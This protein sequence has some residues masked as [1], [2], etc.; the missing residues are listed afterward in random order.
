M[1]AAAAD[2]RHLA[3]C[4]VPASQHCV[5]HTLIYILAEQS[6][7]GG[8][9]GSNKRVLHA[10]RAVVERGHGSSAPSHGS[11]L[12]GC[13]AFVPLP[14]WQLMLP[15]I[16]S[17]ARAGCRGALRCCA[18]LGCGLRS[19]RGLQPQ[20]NVALSCSGLSFSPCGRQGEQGSPCQCDREVRKP[21]QMAASN[22]HS[23]QHTAGVR[24]APHSAGRA[25]GL[26]QPHQQRAT[27]APP[28]RCP[29]PHLEAVVFD[30]VEAP[31]ARLARQLAQLCRR[32]A[33][34]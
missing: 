32:G 16:R 30:A 1:S 21:L 23:S 4:C 5:R 12:G 26:S 15:S 18:A 14:P 34:G 11:S 22:A 20:P 31:E 19:W 3:M 10:S 17:S 8:K 13:A 6:E 24:G 33:Q 7:P 27:P 2:S 28:S 29:G 9:T 25:A